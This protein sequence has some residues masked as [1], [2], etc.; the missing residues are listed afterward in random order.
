MAWYAD[1]GHLPPEVEAVRNLLVGYG[2]LLSEEPIEV[3]AMNVTPAQGARFNGLA[4]ASTEDD[5]IREK[6]KA[7]F[8]GK[9]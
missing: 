8:W 9:R 7:E 3:A 1:R 5:K 4:M 2:T 6:M